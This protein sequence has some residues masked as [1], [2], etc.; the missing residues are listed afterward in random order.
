M[1]GTTT[2]RGSLSTSQSI[3]VSLAGP[4]AGL[5]LGVATLGVQAAGLFPN[6]ETVDFTVR[7]MLWINIG[8]SFLNLL[9]ILPLDGGH[10]V[11]SLFVH[12]WAKRGQQAVYVLSIVTA[13]A[14]GIFAYSLGSIYGALL[15]GFFAFQSIVGL[16]KSN[17]PGIK[18]EVQM[19]LDALQRHDH[20]S[21]ILHFEKARQAN[22]TPEGKDLVNRSLASA[23]QSTGHHDR[24]KTLLAELHD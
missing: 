16:R 17:E 5:A 2:G 12:R 21:A 3:F 24:A 18:E 7:N 15:A 6:T 9:P 11:E 10:V 19:G 4:F 8:W 22:L 14:I 20:A 23:Y 13:V 1:G